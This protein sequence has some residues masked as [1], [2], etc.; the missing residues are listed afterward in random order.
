MSR[1]GFLWSR[2][3]GFNLSLV[4]P[5][6]LGVALDVGRLVISHPAVIFLLVIGGLCPGFY[7]SS[8]WRTWTN[9]SGLQYRFVVVGLCGAQ[10]T[11][12]LG[13]SFP[14]Q[15]LW[16][17]LHFPAVWFSFVEIWPRVWVSP[18][19]I[20]DIDFLVWGSSF[21]WVSYVG[22][23]CPSPGVSLSIGLVNS[24]G[25]TVV[26]RAITRDTDRTPLGPCWTK[27]PL[28]LLVQLICDLLSVFTFSIVISIALSF[29][30][31]A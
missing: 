29:I 19:S 28:A 21:R 14:L 4:G 23:T 1:L 11:P 26:V 16:C 27:C 3:W 30:W 25:Y 20:L 18:P 9:L 24:V 8:V 17:L 7:P 31:F 15:S 2:A 5:W 12:E 6:R 22:L 13:R 10:S